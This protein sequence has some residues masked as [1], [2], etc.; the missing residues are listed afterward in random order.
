MNR[1]YETGP[2]RW[3]FPGTPLVLVAALGVSMPGLNAG[4]APHP[5]IYFQPTHSQMTCTV[6]A[7]T[8][9]DTGQS[10]PV[11]TCIHT[12]RQ[13][14]RFTTSSSTLRVQ[15]A[16]TGCFYLGTRP[17]SWVA[18]GLD[19]Q[20]NIEYGWSPDGNPGGHTKVGTAQ[21]CSWP[22]VEEEEI[23]G[24]VWSKIG[25]Y[26][27][28]APQVTFDPPVPWGMA[29]IETFAALEVPIPWSFSSVSPYTGRSLHAEV[30]VERVRFD[31][32]DGPR[33]T[34]GP[35]GYAKFTGYPDG[36]ARHTYQTK[37]CES[38]GRRC[39]T[40]PGDYRIRVVFNWSG[41]Y[42][43]GGVG[44]TLRI[45]DTFSD[46]GYPVRETVSLVVG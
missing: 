2:S 40:T 32:D 39:R 20:G 26:V 43:V 42:E 36:L 10:R 34:F 23:E 19:D 1:R 5:S 7:E 45:P 11:T 41:W 37:T 29:G 21:P 14:R 15:I 46:T 4:P 12:E 35:S 38:P 6:S 8:D 17:T 33:Q 27:H 30:Q 28:Q 25:N 3:V 22:T 13:G 9:P 24:Y 44:K 18:L 16:S 31:W